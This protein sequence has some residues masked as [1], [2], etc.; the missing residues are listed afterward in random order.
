M[1]SAAANH[2][3]VEFHDYGYNAKP[4]IYISALFTAGAG[5][6]RLSGETRLF[7]AYNGAVTHFGFSDAF[8]I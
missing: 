3:V 6:G 5:T 2:I 4:I 1:E 8:Y 7:T